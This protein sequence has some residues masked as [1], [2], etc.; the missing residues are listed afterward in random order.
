MNSGSALRH[1]AVGSMLLP[2]P[3]CS[4]SLSPSRCWSFFGSAK[5]TSAYLGSGLPLTFLPGCNLFVGSYA[6]FSREI[7]CPIRVRLLLLACIPLFVDGY[8]VLL[9]PPALK[10][11]LI[12]FSLHFLGELVVDLHLLREEDPGRLE[13]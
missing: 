11:V 3:H 2:L 9:Q 5:F 6:V 1:I 4:S 10:L 13:P 7:S 12:L 8:L